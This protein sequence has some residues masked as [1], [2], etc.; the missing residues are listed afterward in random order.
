MLGAERAPVEIERDGRRR[1]IRVGRKIEG[2]IEAIEGAAPGEPVTITNSRYW[3]GPE[4]VVARGL[5]SRLRDRGRMWDFGGRSA[6][7][8][9]IDWHGPGR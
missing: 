4:I 5:R 9:A 3:M 8:C 2:E 1:A 6:E 7:I